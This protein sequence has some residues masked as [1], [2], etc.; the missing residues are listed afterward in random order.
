MADKDRPPEGD[1]EAGHVVGQH[2]HE[3]EVSDD[4]HM[5]SMR[6]FSEGLPDAVRAARRLG[7]GSLF[8]VC[9]D[10]RWAGRWMHFWLCQEIGWEG[11]SKVWRA[12]RHLA[13]VPHNINDGA[14]TPP[15]CWIDAALDRYDTLLFPTSHD[16]AVKIVGISY[17]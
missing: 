3:A 10:L 12:I 17:A 4:A 5:E 9:V 7:Q 1:G 14:F 2:D 15:Q 6:P 11:R 13:A 16:S 8:A